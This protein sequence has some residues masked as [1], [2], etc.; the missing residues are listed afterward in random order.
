MRRSLTALAAAL[1][2]LAPVGQ[3]GAVAGHSGGDLTQTVLATGSGTTTTAARAAA[4]STA[5]SDGIARSFSQLP[6][7]QAPCPAGMARSRTYAHDIGDSGVPQARFATGWVRDTGSNRVEGRAHLRASVSSTSSL[8]TR[9]FHLTPMQVSAG[10]PTYFAAA[11]QGSLRDGEGRISINDRLLT[12]GPSSSY[13]GHTINVTSATSTEAGELYP[14]V[15]LRA[16]AGVSRT[17]RL[18]NLQLFTCRT[19]P[20]SRIAGDNRYATAAALSR[21]A[22]SAGVRTVV[23]ASGDTFPDA[24]S[25]GALAA[26]SG[27][28][29]LITRSDRLPPETRTE[30]ERLGPEEVL[31]LGQTVAVADDV[32][33]EIES[34]GPTV[35]RIGGDT[36]YDT[37]QLV[38][39]RFTG[40]DHVV[41]ATGAAFPDALSGGSYAHLRSAPMLLTRSDRLDPATAAALDH[42]RPRSITVL[43]GPQAVSQAVVDAL[44]ERAP[45]TRIAGDDRYATSAAIAAE[46]G[47][48]PARSYLTTG[49]LFP[50]ALTTGPVASTHGA[51]VLLTRP[52]SLPSAVDSRLRQISEPR[53]VVVGGTTRIGAI[54]QDEYGRTL[55]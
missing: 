13:R 38:A 11:S 7:G 15:E 45:V 2:V 10:T 12:P 48:S 27:G 43:G 55:P 40:G 25:G 24:L 50:D 33:R 51:P 19:A 32:V 42:L 4:T 22:F 52:S 54:V 20:V 5:T 37:S 3:P 6:V 16:P 1:V 44:D 35:T 17:W 26:M 29:L 21:S 31:V 36:R 9:W 47:P 8:R 30:I 28:P 41:V 49:A 46:F 53:G 23:V 14:W 18:D 39:Q 34:L